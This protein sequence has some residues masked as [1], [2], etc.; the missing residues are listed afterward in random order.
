ML[1]RFDDKLDGSTI[2][3]TRRAKQ[4]KTPVFDPIV[5]K[6]KEIIPIHPNSRPLNTI[7]RAIL[8]ATA[9]LNDCE[10][11]YMLIIRR[12]T[13]RRTKSVIILMPLQQRDLSLPEYVGYKS[14]VAVMGRW[15]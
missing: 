11:N 10:S 14:N 4:N 7:E 13:C 3:A 6:E 5:L 8:I 12:Q 9:F 1:V 2:Q 15:I